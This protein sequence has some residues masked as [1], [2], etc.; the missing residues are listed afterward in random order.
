MTSV[1]EIQSRLAATLDQDPNSG[2]ISTTEYALRLNFLNQAQREWAEAWDWKVLYKEYFTQTST[3]TGN[4][5]VTLPSDFRK[6]SS[7]PLV[8]FDGTTTEEFSEIRPQ[9]DRGFTASDRYS[10][11]LGNPA[12]NYTLVLR[13]PNLVSGASIKVGYFSSPQSLA[14]PADVPAVPNPDFL[15]KRTLA[16]WWEAREDSRFVNAKR[17]ADNI[18]RNMIEYENVFGDSAQYK[19]IKTSDESHRWGEE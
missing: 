1:D 6:L 13:G 3:S 15:V 4:A 10:Y 9:E 5:S 14:S 19:R 16:Y 2:N 7:Y 18:L 12:V 11:V 17:E 8:T